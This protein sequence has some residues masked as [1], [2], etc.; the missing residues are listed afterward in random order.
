MVKS[1]G[2]ISLNRSTKDVNDSLPLELP[3]TSTSSFLLP[4]EDILSQL[5]A[6]PPRI[7]RAASQLAWA[8]TLPP[9][10][11][12]LLLVASVQLACALTC[13]SL[14]LQAAHEYRNPAFET[15]TG[16][17]G[18]V[19]VLGFV[20]SFVLLLDGLV[21]EELYT[22]GSALAISSPVSIIPV[23]LTPWHYFDGAHYPEKSST[24][25]LHLVLSVAVIV[26]QIILGIV[27]C[28]PVW[29][30]FC[31]RSL[32]RYGSDQPAAKLRKGSLRV[33]AAL[34]VDIFCL[35][36]QLPYL[37]LMQDAERQVR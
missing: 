14:M 3:S 36:G 6:P 37:T 12:G 16:M 13:G 4:T 21:R 2:R 24:L 20:W 27:G 5:P 11:W 25:W 26:F 28:W 22:L 23:L 10:V 35:L 32:K 8:A 19:V 17:C 29:H 7:G 31:W 18:G 1:I 9:S 34:K 30:D 33:W 15:L